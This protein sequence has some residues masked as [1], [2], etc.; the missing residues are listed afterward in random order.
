MKCSGLHCPGCKPGG[1]SAVVIL[2]VAICA[3][4]IAAHDILHMLEDVLMYVGFSMIPVVVLVGVVTFRRLCRELRRNTEA[5]DRLTYVVRAE[6]IQTA[7]PKA[8]APVWPTHP[9]LRTEVV[10]EDAER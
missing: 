10:R 7:E 6:P 5:R 1:G 9:V 3:I 2:L 8:I 4:G